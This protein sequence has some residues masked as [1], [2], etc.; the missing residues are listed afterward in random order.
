MAGAVALSRA[1]SD[2]EFSDALLQT[3][4][5]GIKAQLG[6]TNSSKQKVQ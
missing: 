1:V 4:N 3:A 6:L 2:R 5:S